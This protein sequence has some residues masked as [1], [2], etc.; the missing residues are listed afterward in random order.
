[1]LSI[2]ARTVSASLAGAFL[3]APVL[4]ITSCGKAGAPTNAE[5]EQVVRTQMQNVNQQTS[6]RTLGLVDGP[7]DPASLRVTDSDCTARDNG[8][9]HCAV[10]AA[11]DKGTHTAQLNFKKVDGAWS[12]VEN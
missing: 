3:L 10:T 11:S 8:V 5:I 12:L 1:M 4:L 9:Y 6:D 7:Y 2:H